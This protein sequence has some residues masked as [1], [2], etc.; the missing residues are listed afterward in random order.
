MRKNNMLNRELKLAGLMLGLIVV[1]GTVMLSSC[2]NA[3]ANDTEVVAESETENPTYPLAGIITSVNYNTDTVIV[4]TAEGNEWAFY[5]PED[6]Q[7]GDICAMV[8]DSMDT[9]SIYDDQILECR[10]AGTYDDLIEMDLF[11]EWK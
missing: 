3:N 11:G 7:V 4:T 5:E 1:E 10:Y 2:V 8:M 6:W 9:E